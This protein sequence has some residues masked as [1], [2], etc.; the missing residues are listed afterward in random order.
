MAS[1]SL[2]ATSLYLSLGAVIFS[3]AYNIYM[4]YVNYRQAKAVGIMEANLEVLKEIR[5][6]LEEKYGKKE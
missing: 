1:E 2:L 6:L 3:I 4:A 5:D